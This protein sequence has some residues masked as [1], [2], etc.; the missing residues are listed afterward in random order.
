LVVGVLSVDNQLFS[1]GHQCESGKVLVELDETVVFFIR[2]L[3]GY[4]VA[5]PDN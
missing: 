1:G 2:A 3:I 4:V 5:K